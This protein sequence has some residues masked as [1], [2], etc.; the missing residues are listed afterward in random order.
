ME[1]WPRCLERLE[2][3]YPVE[4]VHTWLKPLQATRRDDVT[5]LY[6]PNAFVVEHVRERYLARIRELLSHFAGSGDVQLEIGALPRAAAPA[7]PAET[8]PVRGGFEPARDEPFEPNDL[9]LDDDRRMLVITGP[10]MGGKSTY[11]RQ[12]ALIVLLAQIGS[13]VPARAARI[14]AVDRIFTRIGAQDNLAQGQS[15]FLVEMTE[16][17]AILR[18]ATARSLVLLDEIGRGTS[19]YDGV[20]IAWAVT[21]HLH[22][23]VG[24]KTI[25]ATHYHELTQLGDLLPRVRNLNVAVREVGEEIVFLRRLEEGGADRSYGIQVAR[26]AGLPGDVVARARELL[27]EL[28]GMVA[29]QRG[30][31]EQARA[32]APAVDEPCAVPSGEEAE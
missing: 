21:E 20:S 26:L 25:F 4:D 7:L 30:L 6:A 11:M 1:A 29:F 22:E 28:E 16:T 3:E 24:A 17:A 32:A 15:T 14:G 18:H 13:F 10:N 19:T 8:I 27:A 2:A 23:R 5:V 9:V 31:V 12:A